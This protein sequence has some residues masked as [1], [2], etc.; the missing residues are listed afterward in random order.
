MT[1]PVDLVSSAKENG[2]H[3]AVEE[4]PVPEG[5]LDT[6]VFNRT[7]GMVA[8]RCPHPDL[9]L[10]V[11]RQLQEDSRT[12]VKPNSSF[13]MSSTLFE[14]KQGRRLQDT[15][16]KSFLDY[17]RFY[18]KHLMDIEIIKPYYCQ[19]AV[20][21]MDLDAFETMKSEWINDF[22]INV[23]SA[24]NNLSGKGLLQVLYGCTVN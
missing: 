12:Y 23:D 3:V 7:I 4:L 9:I 18:E 15:V 11:F 10:S 16:S 2:M 14:G 19:I 8:R 21:N 22:D 24:D 13:P 17:R 1:D 6:G 5:L 20:G